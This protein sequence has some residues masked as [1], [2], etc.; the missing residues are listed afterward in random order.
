M[1]SSRK[2]TA[3]CLDIPVCIGMIATSLA[4]SSRNLSHPNS[5]SP[6]VLKMTTIN[7][8][9]SAQLF[10][11]TN[12]QLIAALDDS[13]SNAIAHIKT[14][15]IVP[16]MLPST[17]RITIRLIVS[18]YISHAAQIAHFLHSNNICLSRP[19]IKVPMYQ[20]HNPLTQNIPTNQNLQSL[21][22]SLYASFGHSSAL[23][24]AEPDDRLTTPLYK[25]Q[26]QALYFMLERE[27][28][29][30]YNNPNQFSFWRP[31]EKGGM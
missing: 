19:D 30:D 25:H 21:I 6:L 1:A 18:S 11:P 8:K 22:E 23:P 9:W 14:A 29:I 31:N 16:Y 13:L 15:N 17:N 26:K 24:E 5:P 10:S 4:S 28:E 7:N 27:K 3:D 12:N 2:R 20:Y